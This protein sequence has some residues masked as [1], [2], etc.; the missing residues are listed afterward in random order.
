MTSNSSS[1][2]VELAKNSWRCA[3]AALVIL[4]L[5]AAEAVSERQ[6]RKRVCASIAVAYTELGSNW[7]WTPPASSQ[8]VRLGHQ[9]R[10]SNRRG[11]QLRVPSPLSRSC[12]TAVSSSCL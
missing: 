12:M 5:P 2:V 7:M 8:T 3:V 1:A 10:V 4:P 9:P 11:N 6:M